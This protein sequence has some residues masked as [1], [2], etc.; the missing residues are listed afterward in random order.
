MIRDDSNFC[1]FF[2]ILKNNLKI[3]QKKIFNTGLGE[4]LTTNFSRPQSH[5]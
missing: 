5:Q 1:I 3:S 2:G 4:T